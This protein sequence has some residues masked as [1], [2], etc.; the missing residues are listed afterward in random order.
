V[1]R[2]GQVVVLQVPPF[3]P[4]QALGGA[5]VITAQLV[6]ALAI[7]HDVTV[8]TG[9][10]GHV[11][12]REGTSTPGVR[13]LDA[14]PINEHVCSRG[15]IQPHLND[16]ADAVLAE[17]DLV[18]S[19][20][21]SLV[22]PPPV[23]RVVTLGGVAYPHTLDVLRHQAW[24]RLVVPSRFVADQ[25][26]TRVPTA[27]GLTVITNGVNTA[28]F[29]PI[30]TLRRRDQARLLLPSRPVADKGIRSALAL[31]MALRRNDVPAVLTCVDQPDGLDGSGVLS[32]LRDVDSMPIEIL[33]WQ[34]HDQMPQLY[35]EAELTLCLSE[36]P[37]GFGLAAAES[38][39]CGTPVLATPAGF[40]ASMLPPDHG[41]YLIDA[42]APP[43][44]W[45]PAAQHA[46]AYGRS[47]AR[48]S[49]RPA[50]AVRYGYQRMTSEFTELARSLLTSRNAAHSTDSA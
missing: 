22:D 15:H 28:L 50:I 27:T 32:E 6:R 9:Y 29:R 48:T 44:A 47:R 2:R 36:V 26:A 34:S 13:V 45:I 12:A 38:I 49:G 16:H 4:R 43:E 42:A 20:E 10:K 46:L 39:A 40:L 19:V 41:I 37:E 1:N 25:V 18:V 11:R 30:N 8:L 24:D 7:E 23:P 35:A 21:R 31:V 17:A 5:E 3:D 14:F 33:P